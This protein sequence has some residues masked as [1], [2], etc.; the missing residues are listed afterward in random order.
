MEL[1]PFREVDV[2]FTTHYERDSYFP[3][4]INKEDTEIDHQL[5][6][7]LA[8]FAKANSYYL[9]L[10]PEEDCLP[11]PGEVA[12][13]IFDQIGHDSTQLARFAAELS[14]RYGEGFDWD[15]FLEDCRLFAN[16][17]H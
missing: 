16:Y 17:P 5:V 11:V 10:R 15:S 1:P 14:L 6:A 7:R 12:R 9:R 3:E 13:G 2:P 4:H 8:T